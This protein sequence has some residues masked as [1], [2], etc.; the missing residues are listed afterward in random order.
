MATSVASSSCAT[1]ASKRRKASWFSSV[2]ATIDD[3]L[4]RTPAWLSG[5]ASLS[6]GIC[7]VAVGG[8]RCGS[9]RALAISFLCQCCCSSLLAVIAVAIFARSA[10]AITN[11]TLDGTKHPNVGAL[12]AEWRTPGVKEELCTGTLISPTVFLTASHCTAYLESLGIPTSQIW[13]S[14]DQD[15]DPVTPATNLYQGHWVTN[16]GYNHRQSDPGDIAVVLFDTPIVGVTPAVLPP[17]GLF[18][19]MKAAGMLKDQQFTAVGYGDRE[20]QNGGGQ[21]FFPF[22]GQRYRAVSSFNSLQDAW[23]RLSQNA[24]H[25]DGGTCFGT[26]VGPTSWGQARLRRTS[27]PPLPSPGTAPASRPTWTTGSTPP[28]LARS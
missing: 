27:S 14:F 12:L 17:A 1:K 26:Q 11:G 23:L 15:V 5:R 22:D 16:P 3:S 24:A 20:R 18:D 28:L 10:S 13:V 6:D 2:H 21:P 8:I 19:H 9:V 7:H 25:G 4:R